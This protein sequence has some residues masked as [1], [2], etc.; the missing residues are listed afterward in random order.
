M[1][2]LKYILFLAII[3][4]V[5]AS[6]TKKQTSQ[7][8]ENE[9]VGSGSCLECH[10]KFYKLWSTSH[11]GKAMQP[12]NAGFIENEKLPGS[13]DFSL[14]GKIYKI[15][16]SDSTMTM[17]EKDGNKVKNYDVTWVLGGKNVYYFLT[18]LE[19]GK[20]QTIPLAYNLNTKIWYNNPQSAL[21]HFP[22]GPADQALP[23]KDRMYNFN[24]SC[25]SC[26]VSQLETN[27]DLTTDSY[28]TNWNEAGIN[29]ETCHGPSGEH[30]R[31]F[32]NAKEG[33]VQKELGLISTNV[34]TPDQHNWSCAPCH[35]KMHPITTG[36]MPGE[37][38]FDNYDLIVLNSTD[39]YPDGR[40]LGEN[41]TYTGW[42]MNECNSNGQIHCVM[43]HTSSG[44]DRFKNNPND[45]CKSCHA[46]RVADVVA[47]SGHKAGSTGAVCINC[48]MPKTMFG[49]MNRS[50]HSFRPPMPEATIRF[51]SPNACNMCHTDK[52][53]EWAN[54]IVKQ[55]KNGNYQ[56]ET[57]KWATLLRSA[58]L[59]EW[60]ELNKMLEHIAKE[61][62]NEVVTAS[63]IRA[64]DNCD[65]EQK[66]QV[67][68]G[69]LKSKSPLI[70][71][72][73]A[74]GLMGNLSAEAKTA[75]LQACTDEYRIVRISV[76]N[77]LATFKKDQF[78]AGENQ[79]MAKANEENLVS[80]TA[81]PDDWS[82]HYNLGIFYQN[83]GEAEKALVSYENAARLYPESLMP[84]INSS[85]LYSYVGN[86]S[87]AEE[88][89]RKVIA[90]DPVN[91]AANLNLGLLLAEKGNMPEA[92]QALKTALQAN[93]KQAVAAYNL[94]VIVAQHNVAEAIDYA[95]T[96][97]SA[98]P[99]EPK[100]AYT[101]A[102]YQNQNNK[103]NEAVQTLQ[104]LLKSNPGY[105][106]AISFLA[107]IYVKDG[108]KQEAIKLYQQA[109]KTDGI[110]EQD[111][112]VIRQSI[113][114]LQQNI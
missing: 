6:C 74:S 59:G 60:T 95:E 56:D 27:F 78:T 15:A 98:N 14:E 50:D 25:Y 20:L 106:N 84:L 83:Q 94:S 21:R 58:R 107:D 108:K 48:H 77:S 112:N 3:I 91:E 65:K 113:A 89:L 82:S 68:I 47:H 26:H 102:F 51:K 67:I 87:K 100:Y 53:P 55:R 8:A 40:D 32:K 1:K 109:L 43:C 111:K 105:V 38:F 23:W 19:K 44:R 18:P 101:L 35:A 81:R 73:A 76:A 46:E 4:F 39:F 104:K 86:H 110:S 42:M 49:S 69:A 79:L 103:K 24:T 62:L 31:I 88:N 37:R 7:N 36:Y 9:Y 75:L 96:A 54:K 92:E 97:A 114:V 34:F 22:E 30:V 45:A 99:D 5:T 2:T 71:S 61:D 17:I 33:E 63:F 41:Y 10:D 85:V 90:I 16:F 70:R 13:E 28:Q 29:C 52:S 72:S 66:W 57:V 11:H 64:L 12:L 80:M 93:P